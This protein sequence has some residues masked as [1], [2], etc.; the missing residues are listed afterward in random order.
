MNCIYAPDILAPQMTLPGL[1]VAPAPVKQLTETP[2]QFRWETRGGRAGDDWVGRVGIMVVDPNGSTLP[3]HTYLRT[4]L[5][6]LGEQLSAPTSQWRDAAAIERMVTTTLNVALKVAETPA[7][8]PYHYAAVLAHAM[9]VGNFCDAALALTDVALAGDGSQLALDA[10][11]LGIISPREYASKR[12]PIADAEPCT[13][14]YS[15]SGPDRPDRGWHTA[16]EDGLLAPSVL[17]ALSNAVN[18]QFPGPAAA[19]KD[20]LREWCASVTR[21]F[22][23]SLNDAGVSRQELAALSSTFS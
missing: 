22:L 13:D 6:Q 19:G 15:V 8:M 14:F 12:A 2:W 21:R 23:S 4:T 20:R 3:L 1:A 9:L 17:W 18:C 7:E 10:H 11:T 16:T 5:N